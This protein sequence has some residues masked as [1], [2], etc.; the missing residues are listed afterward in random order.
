M[1]YYSDY[2][3]ASF[4]KKT[5]LLIHGKELL[6]R[7]LLVLDAK[8]VVRYMQVVPEL[9]NLPDID[10]AIQFANGL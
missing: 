1:T 7:T 4:G 8:G 2:K 6:A 9:T 3:N 10:K 5:G